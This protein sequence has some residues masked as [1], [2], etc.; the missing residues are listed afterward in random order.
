[1]SP[2][3]YVLFV[4]LGMFL[5]YIVL[6]I[7]S[8]K[9]V[10]TRSDTTVAMMRLVSTGEFTNLIKTNEARELIKTTEFRNFVKTLANDQLIALS[11][12][13][14]QYQPKI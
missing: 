5:M 13:L 9:T 8:S 10:S 3:R 7:M 11:K 14:V 12:S 4:A 6:K 2:W 1:M